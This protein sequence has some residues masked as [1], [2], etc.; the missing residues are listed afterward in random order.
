MLIELLFGRS[1]QKTADQ[2]IIAECFVFIAI[3][4]VIGIIY[5]KRARERKERGISLSGQGGRRLIQLNFEI[6]GGLERVIFHKI[7]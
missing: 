7:M 3:S 1:R 4:L 5:G 2:F 6:L